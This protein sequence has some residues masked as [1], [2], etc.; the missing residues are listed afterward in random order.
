[1]T[2]SEFLTLYRLETAVRLIE[3]TDKKMVDVALESGFQS[4]RSF[5]DCFKTHFKMTPTE[6]KKQLRQ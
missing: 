4:V 6:Y 5:N 2:F 1:M 3:Q